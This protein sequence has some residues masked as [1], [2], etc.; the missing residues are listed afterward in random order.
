[1][2]AAHD[3]QRSSSRPETQALP[4]FA[5]SLFLILLI[6]LFAE[7]IFLPLSKESFTDDLARKVTSIVAAMFTIAIG[8]LL[9][10]AIRRGDVAIKLLSNL[11]VKSRYGKSKQAKMQL[12]YE[13]L[14]RGLLCV[15]LGITVSSLL[16]WIHPV[17]GG[18]ALLATI[19]TT[20]IFVLQGAGQASEEA[21]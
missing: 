5:S 8:Y 3:R 7:L 9:P 21:L 11:L 20:F 19:V 14:G 10:Q 2:K 12:I 6:W 13:S 18:M 15:I 17:F 1:M 4:E 16:Y